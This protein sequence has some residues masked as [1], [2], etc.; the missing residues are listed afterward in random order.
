[1][2]NERPIFVARPLC[3][4]H[5]RKQVENVAQSF[6]SDWLLSP[7]EGEIFELQM[8]ASSACRPRLSPTLLLLSLGQQIM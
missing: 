4:P 2:S 3:P 1:M 6:N 5:L 7:Q 8:N